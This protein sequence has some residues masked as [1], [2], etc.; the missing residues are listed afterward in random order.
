MPL[1]YSVEGGGGHKFQRNRQTDLRDCTVDEST[2]AP[3]RS[4]KPAN[5]L[6]LCRTSQRFAESSGLGVTE[7]LFEGAPVL[8]QPL[9]ER[10]TLR[11]RCVIR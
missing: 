4:P 6:T 11:T 1:S 10:G 7:A 9:P 3:C 2:V 5:D 8:A